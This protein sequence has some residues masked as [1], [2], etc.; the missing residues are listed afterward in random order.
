M[1]RLVE[2]L[3]VIMSVRL[4]TQKDIIQ[5]A[6]LA[7]NSSDIGIDIGTSV[8]ALY[9]AQQTLQEKGVLENVTYK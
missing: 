4:T 2:L 1:K 7:P 6:L 9:L 8:V 3:I 5:V